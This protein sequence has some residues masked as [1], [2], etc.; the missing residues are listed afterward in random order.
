VVK[1]SATQIEE[2]K[3]MIAAAADDAVK[4]IATQAAAALKTTTVNQGND[5]DTLIEIKTVQQT[6]LGELRDL[7]DGT[8]DRLKQVE[9]A[10]LDIKDSYQFIYKKNVDAVCQDHENRIRA[11]ET[12]ITRIL[13]WGSALLILLGVVEFFVAKVLIK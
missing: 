10:K 1:S 6:M 13:T 11:N 12:S 9:D 5:H 2:A 7:K 3:H 4:L 8:S